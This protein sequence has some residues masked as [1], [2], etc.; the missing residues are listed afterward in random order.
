MDPKVVQ[1]TRLKLS[2]E[3]SF[4]VKIEGDDKLYSAGLCKVV[5]IKCQGIDIVTDFHVPIGVSDGV[6]S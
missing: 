5:H 3:L 4:R 1:R 6:R 2:P